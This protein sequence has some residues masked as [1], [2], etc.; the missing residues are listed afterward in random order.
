M[1]ETYDFIHLYDILYIGFIGITLIVCPLVQ[2]VSHS[3]PVLKKSVIPA[4]SLTSQSFPPS[5]EEVSH[6]RPVLNKSV[7]PAQSWRSQS[8]P[9]SPEEFSRSHPVL[10]KSV[11]PAQSWTS[12]SFP[13]SPEEVSHSCPVLKKSVIP[14]QSW[15][16]QSFP[17]SPDFLFNPYIPHSCFYYFSLK[18]I[19]GLFEYGQVTALEVLLR[20]CA[21]LPML[22]CIGVLPLFR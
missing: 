11:I 16:S 21:K 15:T 19:V 12:Q 4:Q 20:G 5:P 2:Q 13:P 1:T 18:Y 14:T 3:R 22:H 17:P 9:P 7:I 10:K 8:F 6:S